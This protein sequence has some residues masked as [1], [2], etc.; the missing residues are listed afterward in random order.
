MTNAVE[1][2]L[3]LHGRQLEAATQV[4]DLLIKA[5]DGLAHLRHKAPPPPEQLAKPFTMITAPFVKAVGAPSD[6]SAYFVQTTR[7]WIQIQRRLQDAV[8]NLGKEEVPSTVARKR[9]A[10]SSTKTA[11]KTPATSVKG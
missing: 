2:A 1:A 8:F 5:V 11:V 3:R 9:A 10:N 7:D 6:F 4:Q